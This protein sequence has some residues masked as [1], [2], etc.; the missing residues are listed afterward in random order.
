MIPISLF[1]ALIC[2]V[3]ALTIYVLHVDGHIQKIFI[4]MVTTMLAFM[5]SQEIV[6]GNVVHITSVGSTAVQIPPLAYL[7]LFIAV[8][9]TLVTAI[10][11][12]RFVQEVIQEASR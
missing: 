1:I 11:V 4:G 5:L 12:I 10:Y 8:V 2:I 3:I 6:G 7:L 9:L